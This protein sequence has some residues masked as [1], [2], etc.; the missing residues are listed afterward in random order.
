[1]LVAGAIVA[2]V[3]AEIMLIAAGSRQYVAC[4]LP[5]TAGVHCTMHLAVP[6]L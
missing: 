4:L 5:Y 2:S 6:K 1:M 3:E